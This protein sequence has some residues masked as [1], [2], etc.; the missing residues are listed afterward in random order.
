MINTNTMVVNQASDFADWLVK[1]QSN[2]F[3]DEHV[4]LYDYIVKNNF[5]LRPI[6]G[7]GFLTFQRR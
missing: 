3:D 7:I 2:A 6:P 1:A 5:E 4:K